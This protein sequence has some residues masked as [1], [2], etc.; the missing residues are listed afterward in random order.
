MLHTKN[1]TKKTYK[2]RAHARE[3]Q[4]QYANG[5]GALLHGTNFVSAVAVLQNDKVRTSRKRRRRACVFISHSIK[6]ARSAIY[7]R[8][9]TCCMRYATLW[10]LV[11]TVR[12]PHTPQAYVGSRVN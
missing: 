4:L 5:I 2:N 6:W 9:C 12:W 1:C 10:F 3:T 7:H 8:V 11:A